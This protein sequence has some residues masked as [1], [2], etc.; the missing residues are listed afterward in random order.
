[1]ALLMKPTTNNIINL[2]FG[3]DT[4]IRQYKIKHNPDLWAACQHV[5]RGFRPVYGEKSIEQYR[6]SDKAAFA[7]A[8]QQ[9][10]ERGKVRS[11]YNQKTFCLA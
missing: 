6:K 10:L 4:P 9:E 5:N 11:A 8:V 1:M 2:W 3:A 7:R